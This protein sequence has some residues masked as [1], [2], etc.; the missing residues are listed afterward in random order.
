MNTTLSAWQQF[1]QQQSL[2]PL[3]LLEIE[4]AKNAWFCDLSQ[5][6]LLSIQGIDA[7]KF[8]QGQISCDINQV[9]E[10]QAQLAACVN[11]KG[12][13]ISNF[14]VYKK[15]EQ[16]FILLCPPNTAQLTSK[17][18]KKYAIFSKV[19]INEELSLGLAAGKNIDINNFLNVEQL[20]IPALNFQ[21]YL[22][23]CTELQ[24]L[25]LSVK[26][27]ALALNSA[28]VDYQTIQQGVVFIS[29][30]CSELFT[31]QEVNFELVQGISFTKGCYTGQ[32]VV[33]RLHYRGTPKRRC[34]IA[35]L[36]VN[37][38]SNTTAE[39]PIASEIRDSEYKSQGH[40]LQFL[41]IENMQWSLISLSIQCYDAFLIDAK[42]NALYISDTPYRVSGISPAPYALNNAS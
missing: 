11:L 38:D 31:P 19:T 36:S 10:S 5:W 32:E 2:A 37:Q 16:H 28:Y 33:A 14:M 25:W 30:L 6:H 15:S 21:F 24:A 8:L 1:I 42:T 39:I 22:A 13:I 26:T 18:L 17:V 9:S 40:L 4:K 29:P 20:S 23:E 12:R 27:Q 41:S 34:Y 3:S 7:S 35:E